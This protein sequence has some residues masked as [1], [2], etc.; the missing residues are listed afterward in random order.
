[1]PTK[2]ITDLQNGYFK[3]HIEFSSDELIADES[4]SGD[5]EIKGTE[6]QANTTRKCSPATFA[7]PIPKNSRS[8]N[9]QQ[10]TQCTS[11]EVTYNAPERTCR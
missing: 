5:T 10:S 9:T 7:V 3:I 8:L 1:M 6:A 4:L 2:T 11:K